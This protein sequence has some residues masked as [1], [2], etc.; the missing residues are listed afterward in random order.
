MLADPRDGAAAVDRGAHPR[1]RPPAHIAGSPPAPTT[2]PRS[3]HRLERETRALDGQVAALDDVLAADPDEGTVTLSLAEISADES[4]VVRFVNGTLYDALKARASDIHLESTPQGM[5][6]KYRLDGV[7]QAVTRPEGREFADRVIAPEGAGRPRHLGA[8]HPAGRPPQAAPRGALDRRARVHHAEP[9]RRGRGAAHPR[10]LPDR[11][12]RA[13]EPRAPELR[14]AQSAFVRQ[15]AKLPYGL[16]LVTGPTGSGKTTTLYGV[17]SEV[18]TGLD[19]I[20]TIEDP[21]EYQVPDVLQIP[22]N[23]ARA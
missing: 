13:P 11:R 14:R 7:L 22:V 5:T 1:G 21:V 23:E 8:P 17:L 16:F 18:N 20:I 9:V 2:S 19:K 4:P 12:R 10:P 6:V 3:S 15:M